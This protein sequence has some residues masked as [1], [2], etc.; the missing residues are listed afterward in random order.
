M[1]NNIIAYVGTESFDI[2]LYL[3]RI[4]QKMDHKVLLVDHSETEALTHSFPQIPGINPDS[5]CITFR[6]VDFTKERIEEDSIKHYDDILIDCGMDYPKI[7][8]SFL[9][10]IVYVTDMFEFN[11]TRISRLNYFEQLPVESALLIRN[12]TGAKI[13]TPYILTRINKNIREDLVTVLCRDDVDYENSLMC[14]YDKVFHFKRISYMLKSYLIG[15]V[16]LLCKNTS[17]RQIKAVYS[18]ARKGD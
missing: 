18:K 17:E 10:K 13:T 11:M 9:T 5:G 6:K 7:D 14:H 2:I 3:S 12:A 16:G 8:F 15:E 1:A 4:L